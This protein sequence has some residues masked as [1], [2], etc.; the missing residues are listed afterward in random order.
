V[1]VI[2]V[3]ATPAKLP[4]PSRP[5]DVGHDGSATP[6]MQPRRGRPAKAHPHLVPRLIAAAV[7]LAIA[8]GV[9]LLLRPKPIAVEV[10]LA[11][12]GPL[13]ATVDADAVTR[14]RNRFTVTAPVDGLLYRIVLA[15]GD[16][17]RAGQV[18]ARISAAPVH[19]TDRRVAL[20]KLDAVRAA[21][22]QADQ[23]LLA[24]MHAFAQAE[25]D[26]RRARMLL[27]AGA[28]AEHDAELA[29]LTVTT[30]RAELNVA[31]A[32]Q[33]VARDELA[34]ARA[35]VDAMLGT[36]GTTLLVHAPTSG[37]V[38]GIPDRSSRVV[39][40]GAPLLELGD[41]K[42]LEVVADV[43]SSDAASVRAG[44]RVELVGWGGAPLLGIV[45]LVEP[46]AR[47]RISALGVEEQRLKVVIDL[48]SAPASLADGYRLDAH[49]VVWEAPRVLTIPA[50]ALLRTDAAWAVYAVRDGR[51]ARVPVRIGHLG[52]GAAEVLGGLTRGDSVIVFAPDALEE[53]A[54]VKGTSEGVKP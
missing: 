28:V 2:T 54:R 15:E 47:T 24:A 21:G 49:I 1:N 26:D 16:A 37:R 4:T 33:R 18:V 25:R 3:A 38:L 22:L 52:A 23:R 50:G 53:G 43:L 20:A 39:A 12:V 13:R 14:V 27:A 9:A 17:V 41:E 40:A 48:E 51:A 45:R 8:A 35:A 10:A 44:Q 36:A 42:S 34:Q 31:R 29:A 30:R 7:V 46:S 19:E 32:Q 6:P 5:D 11:T